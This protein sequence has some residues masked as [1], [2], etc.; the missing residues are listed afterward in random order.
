MFQYP[1]R[2]AAKINLA[3]DINMLYLKIYDT[4]HLFFVDAELFFKVCRKVWNGLLFICKIQ[5]SDDLK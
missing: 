3:D 4:R 5:D 2:Q 1:Y